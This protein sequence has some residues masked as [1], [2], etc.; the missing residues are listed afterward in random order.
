MNMSLIRWMQSRCAA[1]LARRSGNK[2]DYTLSA[3]PRS[4]GMASLLAMATRRLLRCRLAIAS[5][6]FLFWAMAANAAA[7]VQEFYLPMPEAQIY[8]ALSTIEGGIGSAQSSTY[9]IIV[10]G[11]GTVIY[12][13]Q[14]E[15]GYEID[16]S[17]PTQSTTQIWGDGNDA[18]GIVNLFQLVGSSNGG[19]QAGQSLRHGRG[20]HRQDEQ[21]FMLA[22][23]GEGKGAFV[24][25]TQHRDDGGGC[26]EGVEP[27]VL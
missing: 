15:D 18:H 26:Q 22:F 3:V 23:T 9:S 2:L 17:H 16:L 7:L 24:G 19:A 1:N 25:A 6:A 12:Y 27:G 20:N 4:N 11:N 14:W 13:D 5:C 8:Q 21:V 10:T